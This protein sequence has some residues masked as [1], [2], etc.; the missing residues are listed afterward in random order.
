MVTPLAITRYLSDLRFPATKQECV[1]QAE[2]VGAPEYVLTALDN[3]PDGIYDSL[4][5]VWALVA[6][7]S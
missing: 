7:P 3:I 5:E 6:V 1:R 4:A 2:S